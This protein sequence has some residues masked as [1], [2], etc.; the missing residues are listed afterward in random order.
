MWSYLFFPPR[1]AGK[2]KVTITASGKGELNAYLS[3]S[4]SPDGKL[5]GHKKRLPEEKFTLTDKEQ[6]FS[7]E[8]TRQKDE[9]GYLYLRAGNAVISHMEIVKK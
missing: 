2:F 3:T 1:Q 9:L 6:E 4:I 7:F 8:F 5:R